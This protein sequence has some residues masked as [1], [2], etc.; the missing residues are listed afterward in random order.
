[1]PLRIGPEALLRFR[2]EELLRLG[3]LNELLREGTLVVLRLGV[4]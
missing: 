3:L 4:L 2:L 1:M